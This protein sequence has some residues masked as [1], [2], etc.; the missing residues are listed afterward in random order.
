MAQ[1]GV[2]YYMMTS[3]CKRNNIIKTLFIPLGGCNEEWHEK[4]MEPLQRQHV[5][6]RFQMIVESFKIGATYL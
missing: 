5:L 1:N 2:E 4:F 6:S 3:K